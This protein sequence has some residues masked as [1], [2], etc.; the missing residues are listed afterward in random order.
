MLKPSRLKQGQQ[1]WK[2]YFNQKTPNISHIIKRYEDFPD[3]PVV[4]D[5][6]ANA[7]HTGSIPGPGRS[8]MPRSN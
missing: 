3:G 4:K 8:H 7:G 6:P 5:P 2:E 1:C